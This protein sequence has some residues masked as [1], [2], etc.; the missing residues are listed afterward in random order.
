MNKDQKPITITVKDAL[1]K[2]EE[3]TKR[4]KEVKSKFSKSPSMSIWSELE[5]CEQNLH[6]LT[7]SLLS[8][9]E[10]KGNNSRIKE[11][12]LLVRRLDVLKETEENIENRKKKQGHLNIFKNWFN[13][14]KSEVNISKMKRDIQK[15]IDKITKELEQFNENNTITVQLV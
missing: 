10:T 12:E 14:L 9:N 7:L 4:C 6:I 3:V 8:I 1:K 2:K 15:K 11:R 5:N 13:R